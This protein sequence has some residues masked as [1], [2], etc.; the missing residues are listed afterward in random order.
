MPD[1]TRNTQTSAEA[2]I[3][4]DAGVQ[5]NFKAVG[6]KKSIFS[7]KKKLWLNADK[8]QKYNNRKTE[9]VIIFF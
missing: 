8:N 9:I 6:Q 1:Q 5:V 4:E 2:Q 7:Q 3:P